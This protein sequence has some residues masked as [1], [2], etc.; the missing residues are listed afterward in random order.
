MTLNRR[1]FF[2]LAGAGSLGTLTAG[3]IGQVLAA[4]PRTAFLPQLAPQDRAAHIINR[5]SYGVTPELYDYVRQIGAEAFI[6]EQLAPETLDDSACDTLLADFP[7]LAQSGGALLQA[8]EVQRREVLRQ[9]V[10]ATLIRAVYSRRQLYERM[11]SFWSDHLHTYIGKGPVAFLKLDEDRDAIRPH[12]LGNFRALLGASAH[13]PAMLVYLDNAQSRAEAPNENYARE[14]LELHTLGVNGGYTEADIKA[15]ARAFTGWSISRGR[16][17]GEAAG[18]FVFRARIHD[19]GEK[20]VLGYTL[21]A[22]RGIEDGEDVLDIIATHPA[23]LNFIA[24][25]LVRRFVADQPPPALVDRTAATLRQTGGDIRA[26]L[27]TIFYADEFWSAPPRFKRPFE[28]SISLLRAVAAPSAQRERI[29]RISFAALQTMGHLPFNWPA[30]NGYPDIGAYWMNTL[31][32]R[33]NLAIT[34]PNAGLVDMQALQDLLAIHNAQGGGAALPFLGRYLFSRD[35][36]ADELRI[37]QEFAAAYP[38]ED[39]R[40]LAV[41]ALLLCAPGFQYF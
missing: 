6:E 38:D 33:W 35:L 7:L 2:R 27:R 40:P 12:A 21:P 30:P 37:A 32:A 4:A 8:D 25:K 28:Y 11:V 29:E 3:S 31:L 5:L 26:A 9:L 23:T 13:S 41:L 20:T 19:D 22:G 17:D 18:T 1:E 14:V 36:S 24:S 34:L 39:A 15:V 16:D 10:G